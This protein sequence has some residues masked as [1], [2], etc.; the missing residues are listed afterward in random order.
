MENATK[1]LLISA[2]IMVAIMVITL[3]L[4]SYNQISSYYET[5]HDETMKEQ[6]VEFNNVYENYNRKNVR[7]SDLLSLMNRIIDYNQSQSYEIGTGYQRIGVT[8]T[9]GN[10]HVNEFKYNN[11]DESIFKELTSNGEITNKSGEDKINDKKLTAVSNV[12]QDMIKYAKNNGLDVTGTQLQK[13]A[14]GISN[15]MT[16]NTDE[17]SIQKRDTLLKNIFGREIENNHLDTIKYITCQ[18]YQ[19]MQFKRAYFNCTEVKYDDKTGRIKEMNYEIS[20]KNGSVV[21]N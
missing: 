18:Y 19:Y 10:S 3:G 20:L 9:I 12:E 5:Q 7:G 6:I 16:T 13:L 11:T 2:G 4:I 8:I 17:L 14:S 15:I 21:F 1:A